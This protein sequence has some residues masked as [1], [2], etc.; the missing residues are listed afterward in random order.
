MFMR[1]GDCALCL[2]MPISLVNVFFCFSEESMKH[3]SNR[4]L[5]F[6]SMWKVKK[7]ENR[8]LDS[9]NVHWVKTET[10]ASI[11]ADKFTFLWKEACNELTSTE[12]MF[13]YKRVS[14]IHRLQVK[15]LFFSARMSRLLSDEATVRLW[16]REFIVLRRFEKRC[17][18]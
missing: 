12:T 14:S 1:R 9:V 7:W 8:K 15:K 5:Q 16:S 17:L 10:F 18:L 13:P 3:Q 11:C 2:L 6:S 4:L